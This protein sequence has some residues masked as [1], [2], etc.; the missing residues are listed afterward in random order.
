VI[1]RGMTHTVCCLSAEDP[2]PHRLRPVRVISGEEDYS[3]LVCDRCTTPDDPEPPCARCR[4][5]RRTGRGPF[6]ALSD[7]WRLMKPVTPGSVAMQ[8]RIVYEDVA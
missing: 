4:W 2:V 8:A 7:Q 5:T 6:A 1:R 3:V